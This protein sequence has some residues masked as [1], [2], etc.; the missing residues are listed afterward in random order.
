M[1]RRITTTL[2]LL[3]LLAAT[4]PAMAQD[5]KGRGRLNGV[6]VDENNEPVVGATV[7]ITWKE[8]GQ[9][10]DPMITSKK[11]RWATLGLGGGLW[12][13]KI[14]KE[15]YLISEG[16][17]P[18]REAQIGPGQTLRIILKPIP[19]EQKQADLSAILEE[20]NV[21]LQA[22]D[23]PSARTKYEEVLAEIEAGEAGRGQILR[24]IARTHYQE[25]N[26]DLAITSLKQTLAEFPG[27]ADTLQLLIGLLTAEERNEEAET[28]IAQLPEGAKLD[29]NIALN[30]GIEHYNAGEM[31]PALEAFQRV[32]ADHPESPEGY[33]YRGLVFLSQ[34]K[35]EE[36]ITDFTK[37]LEIAPEHPN[38]S[39]ATEFLKYLQS[40]SDSSE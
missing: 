33:Y 30:R 38:A 1:N 19:I 35:S 18:V 21:L 40:Q 39:E 31:E 15:D 13:I 24:A 36:A 28:Y 10:P 23:F 20:G 34:G 4:V 12:K 7:T 37:M 8:T 27:D 22:G 2:I 26:P 16:Q 6:V 25:G 14:V 17:A 11:G 5:W 29:S 32:I 9:G 3:V